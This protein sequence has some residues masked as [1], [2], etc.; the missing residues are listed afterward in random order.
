MMD[1]VPAAT[2]SGGSV[3]RLLYKLCQVELL[4]EL[5]HQSE[6]R[7]EVVDVLFL[8]L[9]DVLEDVRARDVADAAHVLDAAPQPVDRLGL[10]GHVGLEH[11]RDLLADAKREE[12]LEVRQG[13]K[14]QDPVREDLRV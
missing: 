7:F 4:A 10:H 6:L 3:A 5:A 8:V 14:E 1:K 2:A 13:V 9:E 11:L 12:A